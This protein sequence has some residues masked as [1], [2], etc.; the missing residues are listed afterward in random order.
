MVVFLR[1]GQPSLYD[2]G[3]CYYIHTSNDATIR[4]AME[5]QTCF[6]T[7]AHAVFK[8]MMMIIDQWQ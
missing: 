6:S 5:W 7:E 2:G 8:L 3:L 1:G 4:M